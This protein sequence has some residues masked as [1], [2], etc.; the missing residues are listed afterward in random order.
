MREVLN[1]AYKGFLGAVDSFANSSAGN[2]ASL[3]Q[4]EAEVPESFSVPDY[5]YPCDNYINTVLGNKLTRQTLR[6][7]ATKYYGKQGMD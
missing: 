5:A 7:I 2:V 1:K 4:I 6:A 3:K